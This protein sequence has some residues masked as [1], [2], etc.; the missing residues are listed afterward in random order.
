ML[1]TM[2][3]INLFNFVSS[4]FESSYVFK[5]TTMLYYWGL[6]TDDKDSGLACCHAK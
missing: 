2:I 1:E 5:L 6:C 4:T 3:C